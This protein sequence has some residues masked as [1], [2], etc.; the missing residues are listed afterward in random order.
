MLGAPVNAKVALFEL[1]GNAFALPVEGIQHIIPVQKVFP[2]PLLRSGFGGVLLHQNE[3]VP[4]FELWRI[5][6]GQPPQSCSGG[7]YT[8]VYRTGFGPV[9]LPADQVLRIVDREAGV[10]EGAVEAETAAPSGRVFVF[11]G[12]SYPLLDVEALV[13]ALPH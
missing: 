13:T 3:V 6:G 5:F 1:D 10:V 2:L 7:R 12:S 8:V 9:G 4:L 11:A